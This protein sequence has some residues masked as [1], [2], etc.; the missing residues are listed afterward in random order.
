MPSPEGSR[1]ASP[2]RVNWAATGH[3][4]G[5]IA[6]YVAMAVFIRAVAA[7][8]P[9][10]DIAFYRAFFGLMLLLPI[11]FGG[12]WPRAKRTL[13]TKNLPLFGLRALLT[14]LAIVSYF[15]AL[16]KIPMAEAIALSGTLPIFMTAMAALVL[17]EGVGR[18]RWTAVAIGFAGAMVIV[19]P[20]FAEVSW[21][22]LLA[23]GSAVLYAAAGIVVKVLARTEPPGRIVFY[24]NLLVSLM[25]ALP[26]LIAFTPPLWSD[27][28]Y[29][30][31]I[32][33]T[34]TAAH[35]FQSNALKRADAS[36]VAPFDFLRLPL[37]ALFGYF[38]FH[39]DPSDWVWVGAALIFAST[40]WIARREAVR[41]KP[42]DAAR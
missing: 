40:F 41:K 23:L 42:V 9:A 20:G 31:G 16:T 35:F 26:F 13:S 32:G 27:M 1:A 30:I 24:M 36:F 25:A 18:R 3:A 22:A 29:I 8:I 28:P 7:R 37:G 34:G 2:S 15:Y 4:L 6:M 17:G 19:R 14:Y 33:A 11:F 38:L 12:G 5:A 10:G 21:A 39:D